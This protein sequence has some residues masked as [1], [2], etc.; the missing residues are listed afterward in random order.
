[1]IGTRFLHP[2]DYYLFGPWLKRL[3]ATDKKMYFGMA[4]SDEYI[5]VLTKKIVDNPE[6]HYFLISYNCSG[7]LGV[8]HVAQVDQHT[9]EFGVSIDEKY[10]NLGL[11]SDLL[12]E[13]IVWA[14][15]RGYERLYLHCVSWNRAMAHLAN[16]HDL[17]MTHESG[18]LDVSAK[19]A[20][21]SWY[22]LHQEG[23]DINRRIFHLFL[24]RTLFPF[25]ESAG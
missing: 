24:N 15:N 18:D 22:S 3:S 4:V 19:L 25:Q 11:G 14:R 2:D 5:E 13:G 23:A 21:A 12:R 6:Q 16:K 1:M 20:P 17:D 8:L 10:R 9:I 7:W